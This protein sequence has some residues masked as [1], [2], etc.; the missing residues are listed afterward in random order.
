VN[1]IGEHVDYMGY[2]VLP[3]ALNHTIS[4]AVGTDTDASKPFLQMSHVNSWKLSSVSFMNIESVH[5][6]ATSSQWTNYIV[7][8]LMG[9]MEYIASGR[10][11]SAVGKTIDSR[12][13]APIPQ[14]V[15]EEF[16]N[17]NKDN[18][19]PSAIRLM[20]DGN[21]PMAAGVSSSS[22]LVVSSAYAF[23]HAMKIKMTPTEIA[24]V[25]AS[26]EWH[27]GTAS[28]GMD[29]ASICL[30]SPGTAQHINFNPLT[31]KEV[32]LPSSAR[33]VLANTFRT[34]PK[35]VSAA[36]HYNMRV[37]E[38][39]VAILILMKALKKEVPIADVYKLNLKKTQDELGVS[40][41]DLEKLIEEH[42]H[43]HPYT[44][45]EVEACIGAEYLEALLTS[46]IGRGVWQHNTSFELYRRVAHV[47]SEAQRVDQFVRV[48]DTTA[49]KENQTTEEA[50]LTELGKLM[51]G[52]DE[53]LTTLFDCSC[54]EIVK[55]TRFARKLGAYGSRLT[56]AGWGG[57]VV[58][59]VHKDRVDK[60][61]EQLQDVYTERLPNAD[62]VP[63][64]PSQRIFSVAPG[65]GAKVLDSSE[66]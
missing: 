52:S 12:A 19:M 34:A 64:D 28:G 21:V 43:Q 42:L 15:I 1:L 37:F 31:S 16:Q 29:Q 59:L 5:I 32:Q 8:S 57:C 63:Q 48:C 49:V 51:D 4:V 35:A 13:S 9:I 2:G 40:F 7:G 65:A 22:S 39:R 6:S 17:A 62:P 20:V 60:F 18:K 14:S 36:T 58:S 24:S 54:P 61:I 46:Q 38:C 30:S 53:S 25:C 55:T 10:Q 11:L 56:G 47:L 33:F 66:F 23:L 26:A 27:T 3:C 41:K 50:V 44:L 45:S